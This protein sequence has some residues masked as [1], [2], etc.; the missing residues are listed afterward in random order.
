MPLWGGR[1]EKRRKPGNP[2]EKEGGRREKR[3]R[4]G[5]PC[6]DSGSADCGPTGQIIRVTEGGFFFG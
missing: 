6:G 1:R 2:S 5:N 4:R 3:R